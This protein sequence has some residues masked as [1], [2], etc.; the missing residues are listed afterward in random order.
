[1]A[2]VA[3]SED[4]HMQQEYDSGAAAAAGAGAEGG[5]GGAGGERPHWRDD[6]KRVFLGG[7]TPFV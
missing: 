6:R 7:L 5:A 2:D 1:M 3:A 4:A